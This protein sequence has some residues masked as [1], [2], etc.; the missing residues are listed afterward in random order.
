LLAGFLVLA[1]VL[2]LKRTGISLTG[3]VPGGN[4]SD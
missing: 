2:N 1:T 4:G 3:S